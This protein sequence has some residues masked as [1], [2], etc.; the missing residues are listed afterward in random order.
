MRDAD[1]KAN[2][3]AWYKDVFGFTDPVA[4][5]LYNKQLLQD[6]KKDLAKMINS[7]IDSIMCANRRTKAIAKISVAQLKLAIFWIK[8]EDRTQSD[9]GIPAVPLVRVTL[10]T[11]MVLKTQKHLED[12]WRLGNNEPDYNSVTIDLA[13][14]T[15]TLDNART[16]LTCIRGVT[17][18][19]L[20]MSSK[21]YSPHP[22]QMMTPPLGR[23]A[24][25]I[26]PLT[27]S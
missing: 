16:L 6:E 10:D 9:I 13:F 19:P 5:A 8:H 20:S 22:S 3:L 4:K 24:W 18:A 27:R 11:I 21:T 2:F 1:T 26:P 12:K 7:K 25:H 14:A 17:G 15:N 23:P